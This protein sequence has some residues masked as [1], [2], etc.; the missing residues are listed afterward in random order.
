MKTIPLF[1]DETCKKKAQDWAIVSLERSWWWFP[2]SNIAT[3]HAWGGKLFSNVQWRALSVTEGTLT[4]RG[5][6]KKCSE[7]LKQFARGHF[8]PTVT[9]IQWSA[10]HS[11]DPRKDVAQCG[12]SFPRESHTTGLSPL[13]LFLLISRAIH[14]VLI[15]KSILLTMHVL[16][17]HRDTIGRLSAVR[18][19]IWTYHYLQWTHPDK[20][21]ERD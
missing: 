5:K 1:H 6:S 20:E 17:L 2:L 7:G 12:G 14:V 10:E 9:L 19:M 18:S 15:L 11:G 3:S 16:N 21:A 8:I 4:K 13:S